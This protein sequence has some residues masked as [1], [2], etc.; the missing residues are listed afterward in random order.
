MGFTLIG[1]PLL[2]KSRQA[3]A[4][5]IKECVIKKGV[6]QGAELL[7]DKDKFKMGNLDTLMYIN[8]KLIK[9]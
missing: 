1:A 4:T 8:D 5:A 7:I 2:E 6:A 9:V 3:T